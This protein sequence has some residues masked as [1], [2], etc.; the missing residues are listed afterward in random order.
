MLRSLLDF[1]RVRDK[2]KE[3]PELWHSN[4]QA[5][6]SPIDFCNKGLRSVY[7]PSVPNHKNSGSGTGL[8]G[9]STKTL[10]QDIALEEWEYDQLSV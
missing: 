3:R 5:F 7:L 8:T 1:C 6:P 10:Q 2:G 9:R 4:S